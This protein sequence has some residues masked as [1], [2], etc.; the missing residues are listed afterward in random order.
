MF[1][2][3]IIIQTNGIIE[4]NK[5]HLI[6]TLTLLKVSF[7]DRNGKNVNFNDLNHEIILEIT[8]NVDT[9]Q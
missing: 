9:F 8:E 2:F 1:F 5:L 4:F 3:F 6:P 7:V